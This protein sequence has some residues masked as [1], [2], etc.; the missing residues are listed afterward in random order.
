MMYLKTAGYFGAT[1]AAAI[2]ARAFYS[3]R[4]LFLSRAGASSTRPRQS[5]AAAAAAAA[6]AT[7]AN[8]GSSQA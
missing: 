3:A 7:K 8:M 6:A 2:F 1:I 5:V 4:A